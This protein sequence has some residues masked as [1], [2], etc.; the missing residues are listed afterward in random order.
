VLEAGTAPGLTDVAALSLGEATTF[1]TDVPYGVYYVRV[2]A[3]NDRGDSTPTEEIVVAPPG[4]AEAPLELT[5]GGDGSQVTLSWTPPPGATPAG[6]IIEAGSDP[7][8][9]DIATIRVGNVTSFSTEA[10][11]G[12][13]FVRVRAVNALGAGL[14]SNEVVV[15]K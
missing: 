7:G 8:M 5:T 11:P 2:R 14:P 9:S 13:Y 12:T 15:Q 1:S 4:T 6:Y 3:T 10:P